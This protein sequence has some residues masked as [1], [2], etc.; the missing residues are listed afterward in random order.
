MRAADV[1]EALAGV[2]VRPVEVHPV[3]AE[4]FAEL[5]HHRVVVVEAGEAADQE[6][7]LAFPVEPAAAFGADVA[8][9]RAA[10]SRPVVRS[11]ALAFAGNS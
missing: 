5:R 1:V 10:G 11:S 3:Q 7:E 9:P 6:P 2:L 8:M 4:P